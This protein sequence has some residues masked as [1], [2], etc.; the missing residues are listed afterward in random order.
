MTIK[1]NDRICE[2]TY[3]FVSINIMNNNVLVDQQRREKSCSC[4]ASARDTP[5]SFSPTLLF[6][7]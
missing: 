1:E 7:A 6:I 4:E 5:L 3:L 2:W